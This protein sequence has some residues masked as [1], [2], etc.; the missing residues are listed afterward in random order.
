MSVANDGGKND[1]IEKRFGMHAVS[2]RN[3]GNL[4]LKEA[5]SL[6]RPNFNRVVGSV[7]HAIID[8]IESKACRDCLVSILTQINGCGEKD[9]IAKHSHRVIVNAQFVGFHFHEIPHGLNTVPLLNDIIH[10]LWIIGIVS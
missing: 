4:L 6:R 1:Q 3:F 7:N 8:R 10:R 2:T 9:V 5:K